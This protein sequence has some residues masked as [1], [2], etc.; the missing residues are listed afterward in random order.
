VNN[1]VGSDRYGVVSFEWQKICKKTTPWPLVHKQ[2][3]P[4]EPPSLVDEIE[5]QLLQIE[6]CRVVSAADPPRPLISV[7]YT[8]AAT[9]LL[10]RSSFILKK[11]RGPRSRPT[12]TQKMW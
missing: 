1:T 2:T 10:S 3:L 8:G 6:G 7:F 9:F 5:C 4:T 11:L 12:A